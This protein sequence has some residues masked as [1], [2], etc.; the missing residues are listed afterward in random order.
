MK[1]LRVLL[2]LPLLAAA[3]CTQSAAPIEHKG[4]QFF[5]RNGHFNG[6]ME[7]PRYS[8]NH[9]AVQEPQIAAKYQSER[10]EYATPA[11]VSSVQ[12]AT[13]PPP[14]PIQVSEMKPLEPVTHV[15]T[16][17][18]SAPFSIQYKDEPV[19]VSQPQPQP[20][21]QLAALPE[22]SGG[23]VM[24]A[25]HEEKVEQAGSAGDQLK[26]NFIWPAEGRI[27]SRFGPKSSGL[28]NDGIN[29]EAPEGEPIWAAAKG[30]VVYS[31]NE[32]KGYGN[33]VIL[34]HAG[35][36][37]TAY[38][39]ASD[40][41]VNKGDRVEQGDLIGYVGKTGSVNTAQLHFGIR[42]GDHAVDPEG[43]LPKR[44]AAVQ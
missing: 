18:V 15:S 16:Q 8:D 25:F 29:I 12:V 40:M 35:G 21:P 27:V 17:K 2:T 4:G 33:M 30:E 3:A 36:W 6:G 32:L 19:A 23:E 38:A 7:M 41:L 13:L 5:G 24:Q 1:R 26:S 14:E 10:H 31:G 44:V 43:L 37:M 28:V 22:P 39:H 20:L 9:R 34:R 42:E 11:H